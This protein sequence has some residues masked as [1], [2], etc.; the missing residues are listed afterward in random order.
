MQWLEELCMYL[1]LTLQSKWSVKCTYADWV[2]KLL[3]WVAHRPMISWSG[4]RD[5][6]ARESYL[7]NLSKLVQQMYTEYFCLWTFTGCKEADEGAHGK[8]TYLFSLFQ[9]IAMR[10]YNIISS[11]GC[12]NYIV[13]TTSKISISRAF[14]ASTSWLLHTPRGQQILRTFS[15]KHFEKG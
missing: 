8:Q 14:I 15:W 7:H 1:V 2:I 3:V 9:Y 11:Q 10:I 6:Q 5:N 4:S 13:R 12:Y